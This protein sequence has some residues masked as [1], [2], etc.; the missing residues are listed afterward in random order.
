MF[1]LHILDSQKQKIIPD[2]YDNLDKWDIYVGGSRGAY[3]YLQ[4]ISPVLRI[5][6]VCI[7]L[8]YHITYLEYFST[9]WLLDTFILNMWIIHLLIKK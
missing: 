8:A 5:P 1:R 6:G 9:L 2:I 3:M 4:Q 7:S